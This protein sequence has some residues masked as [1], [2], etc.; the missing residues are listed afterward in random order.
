MKKSFEI[1]NQVAEEV[2]KEMEQ[3]IIEGASSM[4]YEKMVGDAYIDVEITEQSVGCCLTM[5]VDVIVSHYDT[6]HRSP[7]LESETK[8]ALPDWY[9]V[10][11]SMIREERQSA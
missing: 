4:H 6:G 9:E 3:S 7:L 11:D 8:R 10:Q 1:I 5:V 2:R